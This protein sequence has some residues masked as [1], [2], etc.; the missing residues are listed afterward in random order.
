MFQRHGISR[1]PDTESSGCKLKTFKAYPIG[2]VHIDI[3]EVRTSEDK[4]HMS[5]TIDR[6]SRF[7]FVELHERATQRVVKEFLARFIAPVPFRIHTVLTDNGIQSTTPGAG[8]SAVPGIRPAN[9]RKGRFRSVGL[10][11]ACARNDIDHRLTKPN[12]PWTSGQVERISRT[13]KEAA[14]RRY[15][16][17]THAGLRRHLAFF[18][19]AYNFAKRLTALRGL[20]PYE[21]T[22]K[23]WTEEPSSFILDPTCLSPGLSNWREAALALPSSRPHGMS[24]A[25][26][27]RRSAISG[28]LRVAALLLPCAGA[29][30]RASRNG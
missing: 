18:V 4:L 17:A 14:V 20:T 24:T 19:D 2:Y 28:L 25:A 15:H 11:L 12:Q 26:C 3:A 8:G 10:E 22:V 29:T 5:V 16:H 1:L 23:C 6:V 13:L 27:R 30:L 21:H 9:A 7:A